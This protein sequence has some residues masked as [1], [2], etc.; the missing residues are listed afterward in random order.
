MRA[1][2]LPLYYNAVDI[3][4]R[5]L[6][7]RADKVALYSPDREMTFRAVASEVNQV[8]N[9]L[10]RIGIRFGEFVGI[11]SYDVPEWVTSF[12]GTL[13]IGAVA[14]SLNT[15]LKPHEYEYMLH[16]SRARALIVHAD[17]LPAIEQVRGKLPFLE[18]IIVIGQSDRPGYLAYRDWISGES[19]ELEAAPTHRDDLCSLNYSS[20][21]TGEPKGVPHAHK[22]YPL[23]AQ[24]WGVNVLGLREDDRTFSV[25]KLFFTYGLGG[26]L[27]FPWYVGASVVLYPG[28]PR[29]A[30]NVLNTVAR[31]KPTIMY[32]APTGY[33]AALALENFGDYDLSSLRLCVSAG[34]ALPAPLWHA[35][36]ERTGV[37]IIDGIGSTENFH[38]FLS[39][40][41]GD[42]RPGSSGKPFAG[43]ELKIVDEEGREVPRGEIGNL[44]VKGETAALFYLHQYEKSQR[45][46]R[47]E[48]LFT[49]DKYYVDEDGYY[50]HA[51]R[52]DDMLKVGGIWVSP[53]EVESTLI[54]HPAV[55]ECA[56][57]GQ[58][59]QANLI[60]PKAFVTLKEGY[61]P[62]DDLA[63][64]LI[65][66]CKQKMAE[67]KRPRWIEFIDDLPK[68]A[69]GKIQRFKLRG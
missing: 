20:G 35:W 49:G 51:G 12:F 64:E 4:E 61:T 66:Y 48:W 32:N 47:G 23:T 9:A 28:S 16:D 63:R 60:K 37:D 21:T 57:V 52:S 31:F 17:L 56:V 13:K 2:E 30:A 14:V 22:D 19:T 68:T 7:T 6:A 43:Y 5:N 29:V 67:Y 33:A 42:I 55:L 65:E 40:R 39:N 26:N 45:T 59:D 38:I 44:L 24:L 18:H 58:P 36:K 27:I 62:S 1:A 10:K 54:S 8:G 69:T 3:L 50:W 46:F 25:A 15:L 41:P 34:E 53:V 11:L